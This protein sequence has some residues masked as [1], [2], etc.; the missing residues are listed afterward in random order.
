ME[1][2]TDPSVG[3]SRFQDQQRSHLSPAQQGS[4]IVSATFTSDWYLRERE[5]RDKLGEWLK[6]TAVSA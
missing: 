3:M 2:Q 1:R 4:I 6:K 5:S